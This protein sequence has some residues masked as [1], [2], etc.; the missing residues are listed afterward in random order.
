[1]RTPSKSL[2]AIA[3]VLA[4]TVARPAVLSAQTSVALLTYTA[5]VPTGWVTAATTSP[6]RL[7]QYT[8]P[9]ADGAVGAEVVVYFFGSGQGGDVAAN[10]A[11]WKSQF[12][13]PDGSPVYESVV[14]EK[15]TPFPIT[16]AEYRG[17]YARGIG[18]GNA[19]GA[20]PGQSLI[21]AI[22]E[23]PQGTLFFQL[24]GA[25]ANVTAQR[26]KLIA[27]V[28]SMAAKH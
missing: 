19:A 24:F 27:F 16:I 6:M 26:A 13:T 14:R 10:L 25:T 12:S 11:R 28:R 8:V 2:A 15:N 20:K 21:A 3:L 4:A 18:A 23:T 1:M 9:G 17:T 22:A 7:A 5:A